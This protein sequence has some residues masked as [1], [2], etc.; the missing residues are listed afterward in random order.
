MVFDKDRYLNQGLKS[1]PGKYVCYHCFDDYA[2]REFIRSHAVSTACSY[3]GK[4]GGK[5]VATEIDNVVD[6]IYEGICYEYEDAA[7]QVGYESS[8]GG[9]LLPTMVTRE[10]IE[11]IFEDE[12]L[13]AELMDDVI[14]ILPDQAWVHI[15]PY[16]SPEGERL[17]IDWET[18]CRQVKHET[19]YTFF[20]LSTQDE[21]QFPS[22]RS[23]P[24]EILFQ[25]GKIVQDISLVRNVPAG[26][27]IFRVR[28]HDIKKVLRRVNELGPPL[29]KQNKYSNRMS[30]A[31][32]SMFYG[33]LD[34]C[35]AIM[36]TY[37]PEKSTSCIITKARF[38]T[39]KPLRI[40]DLT[41]LPEYPS[42]FDEN[43]RWL[44]PAF[45]FIHAFIRDI[46]K[47][48]DRDGKERE[49]KENCVNLL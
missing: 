27:R 21:V 33:A 40:L 36:E 24:F 44:R 42:L 49:C 45:E 4:S 19:R 7:E 26:C 31:G 22:F 9:Y 5:P 6:L 14:D 12:G 41:A 15:N 11:K 38:E 1:I 23:E 30:P 39:L 28:C 13:N 3:C 47:P 35:T 18:F 16:E 48:I 17:I 46:G 29:A 43:R 25:L 37:R 8:E 20:K 10:L 34:L 2:I 32:I